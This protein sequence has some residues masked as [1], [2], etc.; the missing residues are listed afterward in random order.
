MVLNWDIT[1]WKEMSTLEKRVRGRIFWLNFKQSI[2]YQNLDQCHCQYFLSTMKLCET[3][4]NLFSPNFDYL[5]LAVFEILRGFFSP[6]MSC[7]VASFALSNFVAVFALYYLSKDYTFASVS[8]V[9]WWPHWCWNN[10]I[11]VV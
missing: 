1:C 5:L 8:K 9:F 11:S 4:K 2:N 10:S 7:S 6:N 3:T